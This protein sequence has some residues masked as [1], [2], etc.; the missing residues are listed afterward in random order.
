LTRKY[1]VSVSHPNMAAENNHLETTAVL[2]KT[3]SLV[4]TSA[5]NDLLNQKAQLLNNVTL[6]IASNLITVDFF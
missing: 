1:F 2:F 6:H 4:H 5:S 3:R